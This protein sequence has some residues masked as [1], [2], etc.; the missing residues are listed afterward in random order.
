MAKTIARLIKSISLEAFLLSLLFLVAIG[1]FG[2][3]AHEVVG[4]NESAFDNDAF[5]FFKS[6]S[7]PVMIMFFK[8]LTFFGSSYFLLSAYVVLIAYLFIRKRK[9]YAIDI[10]IIAVTSTLLMDGF[11]LLFA[12]HRP[13]LPLFKELTNYSFPSG[14]ALSSF[15]FASVLIYLTWKSTWSRTVKI[16]L[17]I[18]LVLASIFIGI[19]RIVLRYHYASDVLAGFCL[20]FAWV[21]FSLWLQRK[22]RRK[23][24]EL[25][26]DPD[27]PDE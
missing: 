27:S 9:N 18:L 22:I 6:H 11:K 4:E 23:M 25:A 20:G 2:L 13:E 19:S 16:I 3:V 8:R 12:R 17:S 14:H 15:I 26:H 10:I 7:S 24:P 5:A 1:V 21:L